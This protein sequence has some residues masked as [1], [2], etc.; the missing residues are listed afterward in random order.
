M[1]RDAAH[2]Q[3]AR[4]FVKLQGA[5]ANQAD[6]AELPGAAL[7]QQALRRFERG[8]VA[9]LRITPHQHHGHAGSLTFLHA[10]T[11]DRRN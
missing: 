3:G 6:L 5:A 8:N 4:G 9:G 2:A 7:G 10:D 11:F 1:Q